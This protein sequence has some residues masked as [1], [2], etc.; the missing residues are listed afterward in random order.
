MS[1]KAGIVGLPNVGKSTLFNA[2]TKQN[3]LAANYPFATI[4]PNVG[5]V[6]VPDERIDKLNEMYKPERLIPTS[7]EFTDIAGLVKGASSGEGL[8][9]KF[10]SHIRETDAIIEVVR[11]F[12]D[13]NI[14]HVEGKTDPIRDIEIINLELSLAD[15]EII[16]NRLDKIKKKAET[17]KDKDSLIE[18]GALEK[19]KNALEKNIPLR[20]ISFT[21]EEMLLIK[22]F[23]FLTQKPIIY[24]AN[25]AEDKL[26]EEN[27]YYNQV[28]EYANKE[29]SKAIKISAKL[30]SDL[31]DYSDSDKKEMLEML[32]I[33]E[34]GLDELIK[35]TYEL[36]GLRT[37][38]TVGSDEVRAWTFRNGMNAK[39]CAGII[40]SDFEKGFIRAEVMSYDDL[41]A[42]GNEIKVKEAGKFRLEGKDYLMQ[43]GDICHFR[44]NV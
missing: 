21:E 8:G 35:V 33:K 44:F 23:C 13:D 18:V 43:D 19:A 5:V 15:L 20:V 40:H 42:C 9:N 6:S 22:S 11:C 16:T 39:E 24:L 27:E 31:V 36:L 34:S 25:V 32:G 4:D 17:T 26:T 14:I 41:I 10:L 12:D 30:E 3:I 28:V 37:Y 29:G 38:F 2:I 7:F 1:L